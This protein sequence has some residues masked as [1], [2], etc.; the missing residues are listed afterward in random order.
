[1]A[2][3]YGKITDGKLE[4]APRQLR[5]KGRL[6]LSPRATDYAKA[7]YLPI[8]PTQAPPEGYEWK[9]RLD[10]WE[11]KDGKIV[12]KYTPI[13]QEEID[14]E[15]S[16]TMV[17]MTR[18]EEQAFQNM[19]ETLE[20]ARQEVESAQAEVES[21]Q[22]EAENA[23]TEAAAA[24]EAKEAAEAALADTADIVAKIEEVFG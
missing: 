19:T 8:D 23:R 5:I 12:K 6:Y 15:A 4:L 21:A 11:E 24:V 7:G 22:A 17:M 1:M 2:Y 20:N 10:S 16:H 9:D 14:Y 18:D 3:A 13:P